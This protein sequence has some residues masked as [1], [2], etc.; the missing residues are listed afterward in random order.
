MDELAKPVNNPAGAESGLN[1]GLGNALAEQRRAMGA[2]IDNLH[3]ELKRVRE[4]AAAE[5]SLLQRA[6]RLCW[7]RGWMVSGSIEMAECDAICKQAGLDPW[8]W[9]CR[10]SRVA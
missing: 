5:I 3:A 2:E 8:S 6:A 10:N 1:A 4:V 9:K 7:E